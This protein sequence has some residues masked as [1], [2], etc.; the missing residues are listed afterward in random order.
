MYPHPHSPNSDFDFLFLYFFLLL[1]IKLHMHVEPSFVYC[2]CR[3]ITYLASPQ[4]KEDDKVKED[5]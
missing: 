4:Q 3:N 5:K 2:P 1:Y